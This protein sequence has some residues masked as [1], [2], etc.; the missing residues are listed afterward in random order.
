MFTAKIR[1]VGLPY[2]NGKTAFFVLALAVC[3][4]HLPTLLNA[5]PKKIC[6]LFHRGAAGLTAAH[7]VHGLKPDA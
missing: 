5:C 3:P 4:R 6:N 2:G 7:Y 1:E